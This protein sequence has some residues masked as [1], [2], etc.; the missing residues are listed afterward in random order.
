[1][2]HN[3]CLDNTVLSFARH[4]HVI[5]ANLTLFFFNVRNKKLTNFIYIRKWYSFMIIM[6]VLLRRL[7][8]ELK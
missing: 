1:M 3:R 2:L 5:V 4:F 7:K 6:N 8:H